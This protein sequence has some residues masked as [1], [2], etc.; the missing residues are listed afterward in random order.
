MKMKII[1]TNAISWILVIIL[2]IIICI[3]I[4]ILYRQQHYDGSDYNLSDQAVSCSYDNKLCIC[5]KSNK[6]QKLC[7]RDNTI[8]ILNKTI[9]LPTDLST[10]EDNCFH[11]SV[12]NEKIGAFR[13]PFTTNKTICLRSLSDTHNPQRLCIDETNRNAFI[14]GPTKP[15]LLPL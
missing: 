8:S 6:N 5:R 11:F 2:F 4:I 14:S 15:S 10:D 12:F 7:F 9:T 3:L 13:Y 1:S